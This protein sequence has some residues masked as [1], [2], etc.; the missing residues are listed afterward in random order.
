MYKHILIHHFF[1]TLS[2]YPAEGAE[3]DYNFVYRHHRNVLPFFIPFQYITYPLLHIHARLLA[4]VVVVKIALLLYLPDLFFAFIY[5]SFL[6]LRLFLFI[7]I[8]REI[9]KFNP[10]RYKDW[11]ISVRIITQEREYKRILVNEIYTFVCR[12]RP[13]R[14]YYII[15]SAYCRFL[16]CILSPGHSLTPSTFHLKK[17]QAHTPHIYVC[18]LYILWFHD[19]SFFF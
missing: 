16:I 14:I 4:N 19:N 8:L 5:M 2:L 18:D 17:P 11:D 13:V 15:L 9:R 7:I 6:Y 12:P 1:T 10:M 3:V